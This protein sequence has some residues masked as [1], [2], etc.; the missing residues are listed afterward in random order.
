MK[1]TF[2]QSSMLKGIQQVMGAVSAK[3]PMPSL[4]NLH[5]KLKDN[6][7]RLTATDLDTTIASYIKIIE[8]DGEGSL[9]VQAHRFNDI[10]RELPNI[11]LSLS[12]DDHSSI[13]LSGDGIGEYTLPGGDPDDFPEL[14]PVEAKNSLDI[15]SSILKRLV[16][17]TIFAVSHDDM[18]PVL[19][20]LLI[21][22]MPD[23]LRMAATDGHRLSRII[24]TDV[25]YQEEPLDVI[26]PMKSLNL[27]LKNLDDDETP[28]IGVSDTRASFKAEG[29]HLITRLIDG[30]YPKYEGVIPEENHGKLIVSVAELMSAVK[31]VQIFSSKISRQVKVSIEGSTMKLESEDQDT[32]GR[33]SETLSVDYNGEPIT[34][35]YNANYLMD[36]LKHIDTEDVLFELGTSNDAAIVRPTVQQENEDFLML[37]MPIRLR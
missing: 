13:T 20:G 6:E 5:L 14:P 28:N 7:L 16:S 21:Q 9:L 23:E 32:G 2:T 15:N 1:F 4:S 3:V 30:S 18:R 33:A 36:V 17:K 19:T 25:S 31:R 29:H 12:V 26:I 35:A 8:A 34:I 27:L 24:R 11:T 10:I 22:V 37:L